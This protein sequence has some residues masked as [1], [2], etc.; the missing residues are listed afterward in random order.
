M[1]STVNIGA[2]PIYMPGGN[3]NMTNQNNQS[4]FSEMNLLASGK[5]GDYEAELALMDHL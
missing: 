2:S 4:D 3:L 1:G 5:G